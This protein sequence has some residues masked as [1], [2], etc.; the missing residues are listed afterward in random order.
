MSTS[1]MVGSVSPF[2]MTL[3]P[4]TFP[5]KRTTSKILTP[6]CTRMS[7]AW[8]FFASKVPAALFSWAGIRKG[9]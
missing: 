2:S 3:I 7:K 1:R 4:T 8:I 6:M 5:S 9:A